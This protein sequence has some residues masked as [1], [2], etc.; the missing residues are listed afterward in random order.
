MQQ[1]VITEFLYENQAA[2]YRLAFA[3]VHCREAALDVV[4]DTVVNAMTHAASLKSE[5]AVKPWVYRILVN[6]SLGYLRRSKRLV[7]M[8]E[9][10][11]E[12][13]YQEDVGERLDLCRAVDRLEPKLRTV[14]MLRFYE[15]MKLEDIARITG[16]N[17]NTVKFRLYKAL[18]KLKKDIGCEIG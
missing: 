10:P 11:E 8:E 17:V 14:V 6:E 7:L 9:T 16:A 3:Y 13:V 1:A 5:D 15:D 4:Q 2:L 18:E 12:A